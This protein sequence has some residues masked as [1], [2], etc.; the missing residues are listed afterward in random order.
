[1][2][3]T[4]PAPFDLCGPLPAGITLLEASAGTGKTFTIA[5]LT[6]RYVAEGLPLERMLLVTFGRMATGELRARVR[7]RLVASEAGLTTAL[8][9]GALP[10]ADEVLALLATGT[11]AEVAIRRERLASAVANFDAATIATTHGF[12]QQVLSG[13]GVAGDVDRDVAFV[14]DLTD[15]VDEVIDDLYLRKFARAQPPRGL[16]LATA[17][18][19]GHAVIDQPSAV[20][21]PA[22]A[23]DEIAAMRYRLAVAVRKEVDLRKRRMRV[24]T[25][26]DLLTRLEDALQD[27]AA[28][29][30][31]RER[32]GVVMVDEFQ[33]TDPVQWEILRTAFGDGS[34]TLVLI[35]DPKQAIYA[36]RGADVHTYLEAAQHAGRI[37]TLD[38]NWRS[39]QALIDAYD[40]MFDGTVLGDPRIAYRTVRAADAHFER[41]LRGAPHAAA[42]RIRVLHRD[43][44]RVDL[45]PQGWAS[46]RSAREEVAADLAADIVELLS[47][48]A[49]LVVRD[50]EG[51]SI[52]TAEVGASDIAV[53]V[54][55]NRQG[56]LIRDALA[57]A[58]VP[59]VIAGSG[60]V[61]GTPVAREWLA[62][63]EALERPS[64]IA[65]VHA[66]ALSSFL[67][68]SVQRVATADDDAWEGVYV[69]LHE[70]ATMLRTR[71]VAALLESVTRAEQ[72]P[73]RMLSTNGGE[74]RLTDVRHL[75]QLLHRAATTDRLGVTA[76]TA[77]LRAR[78]NGAPDD[79][80]DED[81]SRRLDSDA[82]AV[83]VLTIH[84]C[85][86]LEFPFVYCPFL[87][88]GLYVPSDELPVFHDAADGDRRTID[89]GGD[90]HRR[91]AIDQEQH[92]AEL[93]G[94]ALRLAYVAFTRACQQTVVHW[95]SSWDSRQ[96]SLARLLFAADLSA[97]AVGLKT[98]PDESSI[99]GRVREIA[100]LAGD[101]A[102][103][104]E[105]VVRRTAHFHPAVAPSAELAVRTLARSFDVAWRRTSYSGL[106]S[107]AK[108]ERYAGEVERVGTTDEEVELGGTARSSPIDADRTRLAAVPLPLAAMPGGARVGTLV[109]GVLEHTDFASPDLGEE[110]RGALAAQLAWDPA[111]AGAPSLVVDGLSRAIDTPLGPLVGDLRLRDVARHDRL[112]E[113]TFDL[114]L[115][116]GDDPVG[117][118]ELSALADLLDAHLPAGDVLAGYGRHLRDPLLGQHVRGYLTGSI[119]VV[120]RVPGSHGGPQ[121]AVV[122]YKTNWLAT[123]GGEISAWDYRPAALSTAMEHAH[124][125]LQA[126]FYVVALHRYL[127]WRMPGY[128]PETHLAGVLYLFIRGMIGP[129]TPVVD[130]QR[131]GVFAWRPPT[132]LVIA[133]SDL[134]D[135]GSAG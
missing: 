64:S 54:A 51:H 100:D 120:L 36:F 91:F 4:T 45:T 43:D 13:I 32:F 97:D 10:A 50:G 57:V 18:K 35:G 52:R 82:A 133:T 69:R 15:L 25:Y 115:A 112:D 47:S 65:R 121:F 3:V 68:W 62:L 126:L 83:Q 19:I 98:P 11:P 107:T 48:G 131:C 42:L 23:T 127:R 38:R 72:L 31:L 124:Y 39:D 20:L 22:D 9:G 76:L 41:R 17:R 14:D 85:K 63:L 30:R 44:G 134:L 113:L 135:R 108:D 92:T 104:I 73:A 74:R 59:A 90:T 118:L 84:R 33:D 116:G 8:H 93:R 37:A 56:A 46:N 77:W 61:F 95:A 122:D 102:V 21:V 111:G 119:D 132:A 28:G 88:Q 7:E 123:G 40:A 125:P 16:T 1:M 128:D 26:D 94:E 79:V 114:P 34:T 49:E 101:G 99:S 55:A 29:A 80:H 24:L 110:L 66:A 130:G 2:D 109:H 78:I 75:G 67:G 71:G 129:D 12:C 86:G 106:T 89:V 105:R 5:A 81:R 58:G 53:L 70:W 6:A 60:S 87:W 27:P 103:S 117:T 96:S